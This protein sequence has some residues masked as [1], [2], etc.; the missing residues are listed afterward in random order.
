MSTNLCRRRASRPR[1]APRNQTPGTDLQISNL[2][3]NNDNNN[4][5]EKIKII[6]LNF[7]GTFGCAAETAVSCCH[8]IGC[9]EALDVPPLSSISWMHM[10]TTMGRGV[11][12]AL[13]RVVRSQLNTFLILRRSGWQSLGTSLEHCLCTFRPQSKNES[14]RK[15]RKT[16]QLLK[17]VFPPAQKSAINSAVRRGW[18]SSVPCGWELENQQTWRHQQGVLLKVRLHPGS[19]DRQCERENSQKDSNGGDAS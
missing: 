19:R 9:G 17:R 6:W 7:M 8:H 16:S 4:N 13:T 10:S 3:N 2:K 5:N 18:A 11:L 15:I 14:S 12:W 1:C